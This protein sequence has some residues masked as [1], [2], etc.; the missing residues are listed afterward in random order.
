MTNT[1]RTDFI[2][3]TSSEEKPNL[4]IS[5]K[6]INHVYLGFYKG[7]NL[8]TNMAETSYF[9]AEYDKYDSFYRCLISDSDNR[10]YWKCN[11]LEDGEETQYMVT[12]PQTKI[13]EDLEQSLLKTFTLDGKL[14]ANYKKLLKDNNVLILKDN[15][16]DN[17]K[18]NNGIDLTKAEM[19]IISAL[20]S[21]WKIDANVRFDQL[22]V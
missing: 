19:I 8:E 22:D 13:L 15:K 6:R 1:S 9:W 5:M 2:F 16:N 4:I 12:D 7:I 20:N 11:V 21:A 10:Q 14:R 18:D 3:V 17:F